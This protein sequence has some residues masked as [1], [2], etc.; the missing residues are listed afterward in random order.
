MRLY[1]LLQKNKRKN[2]AILTLSNHQITGDYYHA[3]SNLQQYF[4]NKKRK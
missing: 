3:Q 2:I 1:I 4:K